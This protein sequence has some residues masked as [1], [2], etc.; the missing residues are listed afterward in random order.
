MILDRIENLHFYIKG[1]VLS[2]VTKTIAGISGIHTEG[3]YP[4]IGQDLYFNLLKYKTKE[5]E[6]PTESHKKYIDIQLVLSGVE[7][8]RI[9]DI[10]KLQPM[11]KYDTETDVIFY[12]TENSRAISDIRLLPGFFSVFFPQDVHQTQIADNN[13]P[14]TIT[15]LVFKVHEKFFT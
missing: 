3:S 10:H 9:Y 13:G 12:N 2:E 15:K 11:G 14:Q 1:E 7:L 5:S 8:L 4:L 6:W